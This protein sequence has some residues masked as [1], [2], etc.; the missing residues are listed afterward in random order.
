M[1]AVVILDVWT[2]E[3]ELTGPDEWHK[4]P[5]HRELGIKVKNQGTP[6]HGDTLGNFEGDMVCIKRL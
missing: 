4:I 3:G 2:F 5:T 6:V 1:S